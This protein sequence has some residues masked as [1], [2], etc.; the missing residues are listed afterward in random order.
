MIACHYYWTI[1]VFIAPEIVDAWV[2]GWTGSSSFLLRAAFPIDADRTTA[3]FH[4]WEEIARDAAVENLRQVF[5]SEALPVEKVLR[6]KLRSISADPDLPPEKMR[7]L[8]RRI[9]EL[10]FGTSIFRLRYEYFSSD[11]RDMVDMHATEAFA[12][13][14]EISWLT[15]PVKRMS[16]QHS[17]PLFLVQLWVDQY[18]LTDTES[19]CEMSNRPGPIWIR[20]NKGVCSSDDELIQQLKLEGVEAC[21][22]PSV[23]SAS[24]TLWRPPD[25]CLQIL[26]RPP[27]KSIWSLASWKEG[28]FEVQDLGSQLILAA[29]EAREG[30]T[31]L[32]FCAG[33]GGKT[34]ALASS[35]FSA[36]NKSSHILAHD[37]APERLAQI[38]G[39]LNR[40]Q[41]LDCNV[42]ISTTTDADQDL[43]EV[44]AVLVDAP[45]SSC[46]VLRRRPSQRWMIS[47]EDICLSF[48]KLQLSI[49]Q[50]AARLVK[51]GGRL[52]YATCSISEWENQRVVEAW[53]ASSDFG[54]FEPWGFDTTDWPMKETLPSHCR[55]LLSHQHVSDGFFMAR[56]KRCK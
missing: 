37:V 7:W 24:D 32:D 54:N 16:I 5:G 6:K 8:R 50:R 55:Q 47:K 1:L 18:G 34:L 17:I 36:T 3:P 11:I 33:N 40:T 15:D 20:R 14:E 35:I 52:V 13:L 2:S 42:K 10:V 4:D 22:I 31:V 38:R 26:S 30:E 51:P 29:V 49:L 45:C 23:F 53:E 56:W 28:Y 46:G 48:P 44:D 27:N 43:Y 9:K 39:S 21:A 41:L 25:G 19:I 12:Q